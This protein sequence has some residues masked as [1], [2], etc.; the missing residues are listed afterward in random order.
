VR[1]SQGWGLRCRWELSPIKTSPVDFLATVNGGANF[2][3]SFAL[4]LSKSRLQLSHVPVHETHSGKVW[5]IT[6]TS[7]TPSL[8]R[9]EILNQE[10]CHPPLL[11]PPCGS[12]SGWSLNPVSASPWRWRTLARG[13][14]K[15]LRFWSIE[16]DRNNSPYQPKQAVFLRNL[17]GHDFFIGK[18]RLWLAE[19]AKSRGSHGGAPE[20]GV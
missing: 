17:L 2:I 19:R 12:G 11:R 14:L 4:F 13:Q 18:A 3:G 5:K 7:K 15:E 8:T 10:P 9:I 16:P 6:T 1:V 20:T